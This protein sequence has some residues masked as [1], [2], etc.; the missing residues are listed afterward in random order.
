MITKYLI[1]SLALACSGNDRYFSEQYTYC[2]SN[3]FSDHQQDII[4]HGI[5]VWNTGEHIHF[6]E[7]KCEVLIRKATPIETKVYGVIAG[8]DVMGITFFPINTVVLMT[9]RIDTDRELMWISGH[10][11]G[12]LLTGNDHVPVIIP[13]MMNMAIRED[14]SKDMKLYPADIKQFNNYWHHNP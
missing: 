7:G 1:A 9:T 12:H 14:V 2:I 8:V 10:E 3:D 5:S 11:V 13:A 6:V 4:K